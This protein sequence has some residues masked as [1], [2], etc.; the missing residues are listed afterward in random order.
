MQADVVPDAPGV[1]HL[2]AGMTIA[3]AAGLREVLVDAVAAAPADLQLHL[4]GV[5]EFDS[6]GVQL[7]LA[8]RRSLAE[9]GHALH[10]VAASAPVREALGLFGLHALLDTPAH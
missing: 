3:S 10:I 1:L 2:G 8:A 4:D 7:L 5:H 6:S 9:R